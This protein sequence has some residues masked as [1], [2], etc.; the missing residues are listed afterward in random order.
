[1]SQFPPDYPIEYIEWRVRF[2]GRDFIVT[3]DVLIPRLETESLVRR[4]RKIL[5]SEIHQKNEMM[6]AQNGETKDSG[7]SPGMTGTIDSVSP[8]EDFQNLFSKSR[9]ISVEWRDFCHPPHGGSLPFQKEIL[10]SQGWQKPNQE[11]QDGVKTI[12]VD[13]WCGSG[14]IGTSVADLADE[15]IFLDI[16]PAALAIA[17]HNFRT[18]F[19]EKPARF[20]VSDLLSNI[21]TFQDSNI[22]FLTNLPYIKQDDWENM[23]ADTVHEPRLA[24]FGG[25]STGFELYERLFV[26]ISYFPTLQHSNTL[27]L[28]FEFWF[29][30]R[31]IAENHLKTKYPQWEYSFFADY[32]GV[33]RFGEISL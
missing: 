30:Q 20:I 15:V 26:Q 12:V 3:P 21:P 1:M 24:L 25:E 33:E 29:D 10:A 18:H 2:F 14:I 32:A 13:I 27:T 7:S 5:Q 9:G 4:A 6:K 17:E 19:P 28:L 23:S 8:Q 31:E 16:S 11:W 22:L